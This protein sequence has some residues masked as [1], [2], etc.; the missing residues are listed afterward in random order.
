MS[1]EAVLEAHKLVAGYEQRTVLD[2][3]DFAMHRGGMVALLGPNG[4][5]KSTLLRALTGVLSITS[6]QVLLRGKPLSNYTRRQLARIMSVVPQMTSVLFSFSAME[7]V[8]M[9]RTPHLG[10]L[11]SESME[12]RQIALEAMQAT[13]TEYLCDRPVTEL[14]GGELQRLAIAK[15]L[16]QQTPVMLLDEPTA[17]L[18]ISH[19]IQILQLLRS[20]NQ[21]HDKTILCVS[22]DLNLT[23]TFFDRVVLMQNGAVIDDGPPDRVITAERIEQVYGAQV[24]VDR[25]PTGRPRV[26]I[27]LA[28]AAGD[29]S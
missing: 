28:T 15:S 25:S 18:D 11:Q 26:S 17:F 22:H 21:E 20:L 29:R 2:C 12:D 23:A 24:L 8:L 14:S 3:V 19:Q 16:A 10:R 4:A 9:G 5:G 27:P 13:D 6:G 7:Y 1:V